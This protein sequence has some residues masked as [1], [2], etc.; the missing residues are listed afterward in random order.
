[1]TFSLREPE[2]EVTTDAV[3]EESGGDSETENEADGWNIYWQHLTPQQKA[4]YQRWYT[5]HV[6]ATGE[7]AQQTE[8][9]GI[10]STDPKGVQSSSGG[11]SAVAIGTIEDEKDVKAKEMAAKTKRQLLALQPEGV[12]DFEALLSRIDQNKGSLPSSDISAEYATPETPLSDTSWWQIMAVE[13]GSS[14]ETLL[15]TPSSTLQVPTVE[16]FEDTSVSSFSG[17]TIPANS[18]GTPMLHSCQEGPKKSIKSGTTQPVYVT[19]YEDYTVQ[20]C[21]N[22]RTGKFQ[23]FGG[24]WQK[25]GLSDDANIRHMN[26]HFD[27]SS[28]VVDPNEP[29]PKM[30]KLPPEAVEK[31]SSQKKA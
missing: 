12:R 5:M 6:A 29:P 19:Q 15:P 25:K 3:K 21:F 2:T 14:L 10:A 17:P 4:D 7:P 1:M 20:G 26:Y 11:A 24:H 16:A 22:H 13:Q 31:L 27:T 30:A 9:Q 18:K 28:L 23:R 8:S